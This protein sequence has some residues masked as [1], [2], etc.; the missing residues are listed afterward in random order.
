VGLQW[1]SYS[2]RNHLVTVLDEGVLT[3]ENSPHWH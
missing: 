2:K 3:V 1:S